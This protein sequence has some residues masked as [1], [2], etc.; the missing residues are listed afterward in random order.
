MTVFSRLSGPKTDVSSPSCAVITLHGYG[1]NGDNLFDVGQYL[2]S[3]HTNCLV[4]SPNAPFD[5]ELAPLSGAYQ[6]F[7]LPD[8]NQPTLMHGVENALPYLL[9]FIEDVEKTYHLESQR[10]ALVGFSQGCMMALR[11]LY[12]KRFACVLGF[13]GLCIA[14]QSPVQRLNAPSTPVFLAH[15]MLDPI[16]PFMHLEHSKQILSADGFS[17]QTH[18][19]PYAGH[20]IDPQALEQARLFLHD[21]F[22]SF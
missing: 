20:T 8:L 6:W 21:H 16:V 1:A 12:E 22:S 17:V 13:S 15:G 10:I 5:F 14:P 18:S 11:A 7:G 19:S 3:D 9:E 4:L 2:A